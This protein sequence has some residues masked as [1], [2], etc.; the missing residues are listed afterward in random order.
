MWV[1]EC[2]EKYTKC[3][4]NTIV[5]TLFKFCVAKIETEKSSLG[6]YDSIHKSSSFCCFM[7]FI[8][9]SP[10]STVCLQASSTWSVGLYV[11]CGLLTTLFQLANHCCGINV[12]FMKKTVGWGSPTG[13]RRRCKDWADTTWTIKEVI[14][15]ISTN[16][17]TRTAGCGV[18]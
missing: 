9:V 11:L 4:T 10:L 13:K 17:L 18:S 7:Q 2:A 8:S 3:I 14:F 15:F 16:I 12:W 6:Y 5:T 1:T